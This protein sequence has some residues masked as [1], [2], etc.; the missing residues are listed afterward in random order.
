M[1][2]YIVLCALVEFL[3]LVATIVIISMSA[4]S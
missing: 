4:W 3:C 1:T 2:T